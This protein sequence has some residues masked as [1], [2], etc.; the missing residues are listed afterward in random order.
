[1]SARRCMVPSNLEIGTASRVSMLAKWN[2]VPA[3]FTTV[4]VIS[5]PGR[6]NAELSNDGP[7]RGLSLC[8][9]HRDL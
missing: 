4:S 1:M 6:W 5:P 3:A 7:Q 2:A 9:L 8:K